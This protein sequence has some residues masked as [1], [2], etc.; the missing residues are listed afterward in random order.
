MATKNPFIVKDGQAYITESVFKSVGPKPDDDMR[1]IWFGDGRLRHAHTLWKNL[2]TV[3]NDIWS[4]RN[5]EPD[6]VWCYHMG[7]KGWC[8]SLR[9]EKGNTKIMD[10]TKKVD[11]S[12]DVPKDIGLYNALLGE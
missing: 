11:G 7:L 10:M 3:H 1:V 12:T 8:Q 9:D 6:V 4:W 5:W 2:H